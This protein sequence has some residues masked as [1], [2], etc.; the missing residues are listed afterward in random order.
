[1]GSFRLKKDFERPRFRG[2]RPPFMAELFPKLACGSQ[3][4]VVE[5]DHDLI[6]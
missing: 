1:M 6:I 2:F 3:D 5:K 4:T